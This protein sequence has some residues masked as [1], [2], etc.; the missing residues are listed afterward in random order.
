MISQYI[1]KIAGENG[2]SESFQYMGR[3]DKNLIMLNI[4][5]KKIED[6][7]NFRDNGSA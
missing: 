7:G 3:N 1:E 4:L 5:F 2:G 6:R